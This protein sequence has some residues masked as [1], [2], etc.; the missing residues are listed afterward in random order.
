[1]AQEWKGAPGR[2]AYV[3]DKKPVAGWRWAPIDLLMHVHILGVGA[4]GTL[5]ATH[6]R[7][8]V[9]QG[10]MVRAFTPR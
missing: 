6:L 3:I 9:R 5:I 2:S 1:M 7:A 4:V 8:A 10:L